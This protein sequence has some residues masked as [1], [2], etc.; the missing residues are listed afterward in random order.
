M[1]NK[2]SKSKNNN[3]PEFNSHLKNYQIKSKTIDGINGLRMHYLECG[4]KKNPV[5]LLLHG[6]P[7]LSFSW[8]KIMKP[9]S[10]LGYFVLAPDLRGYG[11]TTGSDNTFMDDPQEFSMPNLVTDVIS[12]LNK[13]KIK[14]VSCLI[15]HDFGSFLA[16]WCTVI[17]TDLFNSVIHMSA[18][19]TGPCE[20]NDNIK[21]LTEKKT[22][23]INSL[24]KLKPPRKH[25]QFYYSTKYANEDM[26]NC[27]QGLRNFLRFYYYMKSGDW[28]NNRPKPLKSMSADQL[29]VM[30]TYY[31]MNYKKTIAQDV[32][33]KFHNKNYIDNCIWLT[34]SELNVYHQIYKRT[35]FQG[36]LNWYR[37]MTSPYFINQ[38]KT[39]SGKKIE[40]PATFISGNKDWGIY[41]NHNAITLMKKHYVNFFDSKFIKDAGHWV[42]QENHLETLKKVQVFLDITS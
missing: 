11:F 5:I 13:L 21:S 28:P 9:L 38:L 26:M 29:A 20:I 31:I 27:K 24:K 42:Q 1:T 18:P 35:G 14:N 15:G 36:G 19:F 25:Y 3:I 40:I 41:Q 2:T 39:F 32:D 8:R 37:C 12:F 17:R 23:I 34:D 33:V 16:G 22:S 7:E 4:D 10:N 6:F 30:P